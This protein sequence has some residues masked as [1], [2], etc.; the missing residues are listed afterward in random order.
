M[1]AVRFSRYGGPE[2][3][4]V[5]DVE[6][7]VPADDEVLVRVEV[8]D[9]NPGEGRIRRGEFHAM[10]PATFPEGQGNTLVG[11]VET[12][13]EAVAGFSVGDRVLGAATRSSHAEYVVVDPTTL[14]HLPEGL[15]PERAATLM[16]IGATAWAAV[17]AAAPVAGE[18]VVISGAAGAVGHVAAQLAVLRGSTVIGVASGRHAEYLRSLGVTPVT[19]GDGVEDR[20]REAAPQGI[21]AWIDA[22]GH[23][24][25]ALAIELG[26]SPDRI[27]TI[28]EFEVTEQH[29]AHTD[30]HAEGLTQQAVDDLHELLKAGTLTIRIRERFPLEQVQD[31]YRLLE[32]PD[33][34]DGPTKIILRIA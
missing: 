28:N 1:R 18:T 5:V 2:V 9:I 17:R 26:V 29:G 6:T 7:P 21:D 31:A 13:G 25:V 10:W 23:G 16:S 33:G 8:A 24:N 14:F 27:D 3:L 12:V 15:D 20:L 22:Y 32:T 19:Y 34:P 4:E 11:T 30:A